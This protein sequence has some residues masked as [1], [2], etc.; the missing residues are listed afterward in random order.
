[1]VSPSAP[2]DKCYKLTLRANELFERN[3]FSEAIIEYTKALKSA[4]EVCDDDYLALIYSNRSA[5]FLQTNDLEKAKEDASRAVTLAKHW[6]KGYFRWGQVLLKQSK[7]DEAIEYFKSASDHEPN[8]KDI[9][10]HITKALI[11]KDNDAMGVKILQLMAGRDFAIEKNVLNP[12]QTKLYEFAVHMKNI[13]H[14][15]VDRA[16]KQ[17]I[18]V[19]ACWDIE[20]ILKFVEDQGYT[21]VSTIVTHYHF[22]HVGGSPPAPYDT[23]PIKISGLAHLLKKLPHIKAYVHPLDIPYLNNIQLN[24][25][26]PTCTPI[27][28]DLTIGQVQIKFLH[29]PGH[30]PGSQSLLINQSRLIAG[31]TLLGCGHCGRTDLTG[32]DRK[33]MEHTLR[34]VLGQLDDRIVVYP[35]HYYGT[36]WS[37]IAIEKENGCLGEDL[38]GF[39]MR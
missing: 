18:L 19:D 25:L 7:Y 4:T 17:C 37:T 34:H 10:L 21:V 27:T 16:S 33:A 14:V 11:E 9:S 35:G 12:I 8:N 5:S 29:T 1:M 31:D 28:S 32:G 30:T 20:G 36:T 39:G 2:N 15:I 22:D 13:I 38:V 26:V 23:L 3:L 6:A 24:R